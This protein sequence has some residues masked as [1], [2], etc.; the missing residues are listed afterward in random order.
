MRREIPFNEGDK[1]C[2]KGDTLN[3]TWTTYAS[4]PSTGKSIAQSVTKIVHHVTMDGIAYGI[5]DEG[6]VLWRWQ[7]RGRSKLVKKQMVKA[8]PQWI[9]DGIFGG[10]LIVEH[11]V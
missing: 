6:V 7:K 5:D 10:E 11:S 9:M 1:A 2:E 8:F 3:I 4:E